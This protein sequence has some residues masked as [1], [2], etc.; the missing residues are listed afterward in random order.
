[1]HAVGVGTGD[2]DEGAVLDAGFCDGE[3]DAAGAAD[4]EDTGARELGGIFGCVGHGGG[5]WD[6]YE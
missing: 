1:L 2:R 3:A 4:D 5:R 6:V